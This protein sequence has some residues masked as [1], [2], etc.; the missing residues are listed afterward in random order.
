MCLIF[1]LCLGDEAVH[2]YGVIIFF[3]CFSRTFLLRHQV[4]L[5]IS[6]AWGE[7]QGMTRMD[8]VRY[9]E[10]K[11]PGVALMGALV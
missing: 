11:S 7:R 10:S 2:L 4:V 9:A 1:I 8:R 6:E 3:C 5:L